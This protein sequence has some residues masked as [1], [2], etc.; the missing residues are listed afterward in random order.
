MTEKEVL[1]LYDSGMSATQIGKKF[2]KFTTSITR[3]LKRNG[4]KISDGKGKNHSG[5]KGGR[6]LKSGYWTVYKPDHPRAMNIRRVWEHI[7]VMEK[8]LGRPITKK[9]HIHHI[10]FDRQNNDP[11]NLYVCSGKEHSNIHGS[12]EQVVCKL[13]KQGIIKFVDGKYA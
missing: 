10:D 8:H 5:W 1:K 7:L 3:I 13:F 6:G 12:L 9:E 11:K 4:R 2:G